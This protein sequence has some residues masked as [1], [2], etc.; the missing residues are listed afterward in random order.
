[1]V[2]SSIA[3]V[4]GVQVR[5]IVWLGPDCQ[6]EDPTAAQSIAAVRWQRNLRSAL[7]LQGAVA[8]IGYLALPRWPKGPAIQLH[9]R[10]SQLISYLNTFPL[11]ELSLAFSAASA[12]E[13]RKPAALVTYNLRPAHVLAAMLL[14]RPWIPIVADA[15]GS[16]VENL[17]ARESLRLAAGIVYLS[18]DSFERSRHPR[19]LHLDGGVS[20]PGSS[21]AGPRDS[22]TFVYAGALS[23]YTGI[24][25]LLDATRLITDSRFRLEIYGKGG[26]AETS[27]VLHICRSDARVR[28]FGVV[29]DAQL[30]AACSRAFA[31]VN[32]RPVSLGASAE[33]FPSKLLEYLPHGRPI[34]STWTPGLA[35]EY[36]RI[37]DVCEPSSSGIANCINRVMHYDER[38]LQDVQ[39]RLATFCRSSRLW[40]IQAERFWKF[41][42]EVTHGAVRNR[43]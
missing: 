8:P 6:Q 3:I 41:F 25:A 21:E 18:Y 17:I 31:F 40:V 27:A 16:K 35:P 12:V 13:K 39:V 34:V 19:K 2:D 33:N 38:M 43:P 28:Y 11:R 15:S 10:R 26:R 30:A 36:R 5:S 9:S 20:D 23:C 37:L 32:P 7:S 1:M 22:R 14:G 42:D 4:R 24:S 29:S